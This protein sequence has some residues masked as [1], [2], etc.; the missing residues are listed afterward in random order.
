MILHLH[1]VESPLPMQGYFVNRP[2]GTGEEDSVKWIYF[3][4]YIMIWCGP[5]RE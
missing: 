4:Y 1:K 5:S 3:H 2:S